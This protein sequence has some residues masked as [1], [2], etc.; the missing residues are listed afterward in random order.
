V[1]G[2]QTRKNIDELTVDLLK[3]RKEAD[4]IYD[5]ERNAARKKRDDAHKAAQE[6]FEEGYSKSYESFS[7]TVKTTNQE[8][9]K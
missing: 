3:A 1:N 8:K 2:E 9:Q 5:A 6:A 7:E 4:D